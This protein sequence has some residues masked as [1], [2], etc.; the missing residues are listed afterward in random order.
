MASGG[1]AAP[2][3]NHNQNKIGFLIAHLQ[4]PCPHIA[5]SAAAAVTLSTVTSGD[6]DLPIEIQTA[7]SE[8]I[9]EE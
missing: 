2:F 1:T 6:L 9:E 3:L 5:A 7:K 8:E 4:L